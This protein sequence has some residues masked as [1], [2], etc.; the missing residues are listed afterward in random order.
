M[1]SESFWRRRFGARPDMVGQ[2]IVL[3]DVAFTVVGIARADF[4]GYWGVVRRW[5][6]FRSEDAWI[7]TAMAPIGMRSTR[8]RTPSLLEDPN[9]QA[10]TAVARIRRGSGLPAL[11]D[12]LDRLR[13]EVRRLWP[14]S[15]AWHPVPFGIVPLSVDA[16]D[17][18]VV[19]TVSLLTAVGWVVVVL[20]AFDV[21]VLFLARGVSRAHSTEVE[22]ALGASRVGLV[23]G[24]LG[25][26]LVVGLAGGAVALFAGAAGP[27]L[28]GLI[29]PSFASHPFGASLS[30]S[31]WRIEGMSVLAALGLAVA[32]A[33]GGALLPAWHAARASAARLLRSGAS[34][35]RAG[36][37]SLRLGRPRGVLV[38]AHLAL[39][40]ALTL[41][42]LL[43]LRSVGRLVAADLG[44]DARGAFA[45]SLSLPPSRYSDGETR[46][47]LAA[48]L[49]RVR[50]APGVDAAAWVSTLPLDGSFTSDVA[51]SGDTRKINA[52]IVAVSPD[53]FRSLGVGLRIGSDFP[54]SGEERQP[55]VVLSDLAARRLGV[56][57]GSYVRVSAFG[58][59]LVQVV[60][61][62]TDV[63][64]ADPVETA[65]PVVYVPMTMLSSPDGALIVRTNRPKEVVGSLVREILAEQDASIAPTTTFSLADHRRHRLSRFRVAALLMVAAALLS[66]TLAALGVYGVLSSLVAGASAEVGVRM[67]LG[68]TPSGIA[69]ELVAMTLRLSA[70]GLTI[71][72]ALGVAGSAP[73]RSY[74]YGVGRGDAV[75]L[76]LASVVASTLA[77]AT[78]WGP[79]RRASRVDPAVALRSE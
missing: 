64:F 2:E 7:P 55:L 45:T 34:A 56:G 75:A 28:L 26:A 43:L 22:L 21:G 62:A 4:S 33:V 19:R 10:F 38:A 8:S 11:S 39:G 32:A 20:G 29:E 12:E 3:N 24:V 77:F 48:V 52:T 70:V 16:I 67:A 72:A 37:A 74:L 42:A 27:R 53:A 18:T 44:F 63:P 79:A 31:D 13:A 30:P 15:L 78:A 71:G 25:E 76:F 40:V 23:L 49:D 46:R 60:A 35:N 58:Q 68:A 57:P 61:V 5:A 66:L 17:P 65:R 14:E 6:G 51:A 9:L 54:E 59:E 41:P 69:R 73:L 1:L 47:L 50:R 36:L